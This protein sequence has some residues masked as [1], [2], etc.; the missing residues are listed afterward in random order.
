MISP[1][2]KTTKPTKSPTPSR[3]PTKPTGIIGAVRNDEQRK[4]MMAKMKGGRRA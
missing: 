3:A 2:P 1:V 4:A